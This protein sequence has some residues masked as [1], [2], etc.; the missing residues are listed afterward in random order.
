MNRVLPARLIVPPAP[1]ARRVLPV[2]MVR[3]ARLAPPVLPV[4]LARRVLPVTMVRLAR[5]VP[6]VPLVPPDRRARQV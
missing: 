5:L 4:T 1:P 2:T 6:P 3:T